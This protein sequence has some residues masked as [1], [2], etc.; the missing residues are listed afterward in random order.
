MITD[1]QEKNISPF[2]SPNASSI[3]KVALPTPM[4]KGEL[5]KDNSVRNMSSPLPMNPGT[6][7]RQKG[8][9][10][11]VYRKTSR[12]QAS[13][14]YGGMQTQSSNIQR[15]TSFSSHATM[16][17][18]AQSM[19][20]ESLVSQPSSKSTTVP[21]MEQLSNQERKKP[22]I[23]R[24]ESYRKARG[25]A[26]DEERPGISENTRQQSTYNSLPRRGQR[27]Q[28]EQ[29]AGLPRAN[30]EDSL[31]NAMKRDYDQDMSGSKTRRK[32]GREGECSVM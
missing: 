24:T 4:I 18:D 32:K 26:G 25:G 23:S 29:N 16:D 7:S 15:Q 31:Q 5:L 13:E 19:F 20:M 8:R 6:S 9:Q 14:Y 17:N 21:R 10:S 12:A 11:G 22:S 27:N 1:R 2:Q 30:S 3:S 28:R